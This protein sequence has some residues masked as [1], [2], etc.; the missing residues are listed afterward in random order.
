MAIFQD[1]P[2]KLVPESIVDFIGAEDA[3]SGADN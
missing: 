3:G 1:N 2:D